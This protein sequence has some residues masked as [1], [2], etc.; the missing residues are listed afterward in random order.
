MKKHL[1]DALIQ[2]TVG[3]MLLNIGAGSQPHEAGNSLPT[4][5]TPEL[6]RVHPPY[7]MDG[8]HNWASFRDEGLGAGQV[9]GHINRRLNYPS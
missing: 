1:I 3:L 6:I 5:Q 4:L 7:S 8:A 9:P 2:F